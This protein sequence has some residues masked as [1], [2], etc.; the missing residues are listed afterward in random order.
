MFGAWD[1]V[2][3]LIPK[4]KFTRLESIGLNRFEI[5]CRCPSS[6]VFVYTVH[7]VYMLLGNH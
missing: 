7:D 4:E 5:I 2:V 3:V 1:Y 6:Q